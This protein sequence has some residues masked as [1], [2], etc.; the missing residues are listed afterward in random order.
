MNQVRI[1]I[2]PEEKPCAKDI[3]VLDGL[4]TC[5]VLVPSPSAELTPS[6]IPVSDATFGT[7]SGR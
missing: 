4:M 2:S 3:L 7:V 5:D 6:C 1:A